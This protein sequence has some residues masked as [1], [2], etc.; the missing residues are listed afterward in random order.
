MERHGHYI[1]YI[2]YFCHFQ[3]AVIFKKIKENHRKKCDLLI[4]LM[5]AIETKIDN[6]P[7]KDPLWKQLNIICKDY[8]VIF[9]KQRKVLKETLCKL[10]VTGGYL[11]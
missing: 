2:A 4:T 10:I 11:D 8:K 3:L 5:D 7:E 6:V 9:E 1:P